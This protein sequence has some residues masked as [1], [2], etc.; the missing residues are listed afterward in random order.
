MKNKGDF[1]IDLLTSKNLSTN[2][3]ERILK[4]SAKEYGKNSEELMNL[5]ERIHNVEVKK[6]SESKSSFNHNDYINPTLL[7]EFLIAFNQNPILKTTCHKIDESELER[8]VKILEIESY[9]FNK[10]LKKIHEEYNN[11]T[12]KYQDSKIKI[13]ELIR[14]YLT[15]E[16]QGFWSSDKINI[17]WGNHL[18]IQ[19]A[20]SNPGI[21][22]NPDEDVILKLENIGYEF[23]TVEVNWGN[24]RIQTFSHLVIH[25][26][27]MFHIRSDNQLRNLIYKRNIQKKWNDKVLFDIDNEDFWSNIEL[28]SDVDKIIQA[29]VKI[30]EMILEV[31][32]K[33][34]LSKPRVKLRFKEEGDS[35]IFS[36]HHQ[37]S[38]FKRT[39]QNIKEGRFG[40]KLTDL[41]Q[42]QINGLCDFYIRADFDNNQ[43]A[44]VNLWNG[45]A[46]EPKPLKSHVGVE[47][48]LKFKG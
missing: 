40:T 24:D 12:K 37:N 21:P 27:H 4:L 35:I 17:N 11:L 42:N 3:R 13:K 43:F 22:P 28:F 30:I 14:V 26:K 32:K 18:L 19:W 34:N 39:I 31:T 36:I 15:G 6:Q 44:H 1:I 2:D 46:I 23:D 29:Y 38:K 20:K 47:F 7:K 25:F 5:K 9:D 33:N 10:H 48:I 16:G 8:L 41:I 45:K